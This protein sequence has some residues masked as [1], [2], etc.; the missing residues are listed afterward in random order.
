MNLENSEICLKISPEE[1]DHLAKE[2]KKGVRQQIK[3]SKCKKCPSGFEGKI[4]LPYC[5]K[6]SDLTIVFLWDLSMLEM[7]EE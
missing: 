5:C 2:F 4:A 7:K 1:F 6:N 3:N